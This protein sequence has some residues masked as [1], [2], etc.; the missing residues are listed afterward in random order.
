[1]LKLFKQEIARHDPRPSKKP[2]SL[3]GHTDPVDLST[4]LS[5]RRFV[6]RS[7]RGA[8]SII[9]SSMAF[10]LPAAGRQYFFNGHIM[11][12]MKIRQIFVRL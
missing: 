6:E 2:F 9:D 10:D 11:P 12:S 5:N 3:E 4:I 7:R 1:M 8:C